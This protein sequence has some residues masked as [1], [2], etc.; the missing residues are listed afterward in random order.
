MEQI[1]VVKVDMEEMGEVN[2]R[3]TEESVLNK[4]PIMM[5][6]FMIKIKDT[7]ERIIVKR[8]KDVLQ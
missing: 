5:T 3:M 2:L 1:E 7:P 4:I 6:K 8:I